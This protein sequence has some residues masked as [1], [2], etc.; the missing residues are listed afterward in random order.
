MGWDINNWE[1][2]G[3]LAT[4]VTAAVAVFSA[5]FAFGQIFSQIKATREVR[6]TEAYD[7]YL[8]LCVEKPEFSSTTA[9]QKR[10]NRAP[11]PDAATNSNEDEQYLWFVSVMLNAGEQIILSAPKSQEWQ[12]SLISQMSYHKTTLKLVW[13]DWKRHYS[14]QLQKLVQEA[15]PQV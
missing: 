14:Q 1:A 15:V 6:A 8:K 11:N 5:G 9:F 10:F 7:A 13:G 3:N 4:V 12:S 2:V